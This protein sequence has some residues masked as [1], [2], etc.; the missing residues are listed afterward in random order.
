MQRPPSIPHASEPAYEGPEP[1]Q[2]I[3][4]ALAQLPI[5][6]RMAIVL[7]DYA[8]RPADEVA[9][10]MGLARATVYVHLS[11]GRKRLRTLLEESSDA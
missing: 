4:R 2:D 11:A 7:H 1:V 8:D 10:T 3:V 6:Q 5:R 9:R